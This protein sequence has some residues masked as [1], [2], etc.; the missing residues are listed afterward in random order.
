MR[1]FEH[2]QNR[3]KINDFCRNMYYVLYLN[4]TVYG[5]KPINL[6]KVIFEDLF[7]IVDLLNKL[8]KLRTIEFSSADFK[9]RQLTILN[10]S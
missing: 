1:G 5:G 7:M 10:T 6:Y 4:S 8:V 2:R 9:P 3:Q